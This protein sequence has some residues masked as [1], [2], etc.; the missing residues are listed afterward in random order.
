MAKDVAHPMRLEDLSE[1][2][3][4]RI[5]SIVFCC[6]GPPP[7]LSEALVWRAAHPMSGKRPGGRPAG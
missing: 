5:E 1:A 7:A 6:G 3:I 4:E 2:E